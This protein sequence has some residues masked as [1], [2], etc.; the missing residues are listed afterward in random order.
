MLRVSRLIAATALLAFPV[1]AGAAN[2]K[3]DYAITLGGLSLG[4]ADLIATFDDTRYD[5]TISGRMSGLVGTLSGGS[6]G[7]ATARGVFAGTKLVSTGFSATGKS[8]SNT[9]TVQIG[10]ANGNVTTV[11]I[12]PP[13]EERPDR[14]PLTD[15]SKRGIIDPLSGLVAV[16]AN[17]AKPDEPGNCNRS[18]PVFDGTQRF[19]IELS[20]AGTRLVRKPGFTGN[21]LVCSI[22]YV[23]VAGHRPQRDAVK[24]MQDNREMTVWLAPVQGTR[25]LVPIRISLETMVGTSVLEA[26]RWSVEKSQ[27]R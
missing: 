12:E 10:V 22:R 6:K 11:S 26:Q 20:Y 24:F 13:F 1:A 8:G 14:V 9:R 17:P 15:A 4:E 5:M 21:V 23:P 2:L 7:G 19:N 27:T 3:V 18:I 25:V 16:A